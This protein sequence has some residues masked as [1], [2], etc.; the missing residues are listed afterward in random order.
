MTNFVPRVLTGF[1]GDVISV[2]LGTIGGWLIALASLPLITRLYNHENFHVL[3]VNLALVSTLAVAACLGLEVA[4]PLVETDA[5]A[6]NLLALGFTVL[7]RT[8]A[9]LTLPALM[10]PYIN[11]Y[12]LGAPTLAPLMWLAPLGVA[13]GSSCSILQ[14]V[15]NYLTSRSILIFFRKP[16]PSLAI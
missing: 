10:M 9:V 14:I 7:T 3:A 15:S 16:S 5:E 12:A 1:L 2:Y 11:V 8:T 4:I 6:A 13:M